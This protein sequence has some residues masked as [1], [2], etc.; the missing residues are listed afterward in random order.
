MRRSVRILYRVLAQKL[1]LMK[2]VMLLFV[3]VFS[4]LFVFSQQLKPLFP[5]GEI[6]HSKQLKTGSLDVGFAEGLTFY[7]VKATSGDKTLRYV[8]LVY[9]GPT[10]N[11]CKS[12][13]TYYT[14]VAPDEIAGLQE[15]L[16]K[17]VE[18][19]Q[20]ETNVGNK[21]SKEIYTYRLKN[22]LAFS[23]V[24]GKKSYLAISF[25]TSDCKKAYFK[26]KNVEALAQ[27][28]DIAV[29]KAQTLE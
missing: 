3:F 17:F 15:A 21:K 23:Y 19:S 28:F 12:Y 22:G 11:N 18:L 10:G 6:V 1:K 4:F 14:Y 5:P 20:K 27:Q 2:R 7:V 16:K 29:Q 24:I 9:G 26:V 25:I 8:K 13:D